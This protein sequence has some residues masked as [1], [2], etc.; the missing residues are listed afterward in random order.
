MQGL[1]TPT[2]SPAPQEPGRLE[3]G[4][5]GTV[6]RSLRGEGDTVTEVGEVARSLGGKVARS[7]RGE[8]GTVTWGK[9]TRSL[10]GQ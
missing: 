4:S 9:V 5:V 10:G 3:W 2:C 1:G 7:L 6:T 8:G